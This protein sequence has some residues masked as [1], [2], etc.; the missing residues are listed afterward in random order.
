M[1]LASSP[2]ILYSPAESA[3]ISLSIRLQRLLDLAW[4]R[5]GI[6]ALFAAFTFFYG[7]HV[8]DL[9]RTEN[10]RALV[11]RGMMESGD[12]VVPRLFG[13][14]LFTKP[15]GMYI[16]IAICSWP[17]GDVTPFSARLPSAIAGSVSVFLFA[18][19]F[20]RRLG[21][22]AG[23]IAGLILPMSVVWLEKSTSAEID[24]LY[25]MFVIASI[26]FF[27]RAVEKEDDRPHFGWWM[28]ALEC[29]AAANLTKW[30]GFVFFYGTAIP[31]LAIRGR[32]RELFRWPHL[33]AA[34]IAASACLGWLW[35]AV[36]REGWEEFVGT[37]RQEGMPRF[38]PTHFG[39]QFTWRRAA[40]H[41]FRIWA[42]C[43]F[44]S[45]P[46]LLAFL[47]R[48]RQRWDEPGRRLWLG[49]S[50][51]LW[52]QVIFWSLV[53][54]HAIRHAFPAFPAM[55]GF[56]AMVW[57]A[58]HEGRLAWPSTRFTPTHFFLCAIAVWIT[59]KVIHVE[60]MI[61]IRNAQRAY[62]QRGDKMAEAVPGDQTL[63]VVRAKDEG[64][65][66]HYRRPVQRVRS[67]AAIPATGTYC[68]LAH[69]DWAELRKTRSGEVL[70]DAPDELGEPSILVHCAPV[71][72][73]SASAAP[74]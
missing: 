19:F 37:I 24:M 55:A 44:W 9:Y 27:F 15:P 53:N 3:P 69:A 16:A 31:Y 65:A 22:N 34:V 51:W 33:V 13:L 43:L 58:W 1:N 40:L 7:L 70:L 62:P 64:M 21:S 6:L 39:E 50:C 45:V 14:P 60:R 4:V 10:L 20:G 29:V 11:A 8:G 35:L 5:C 48:F 41:P 68:Y 36:H 61:P 30:T 74:Q 18:W 52:P 2:A 54:E 26:L 73:Q 28:A 71:P 63:F 49:L 67:L 32:W 59:V 47:P 42:A 12:Y 72:S 38:A 17:F 46:A 57:L 56:A 23:L 25:C 66:F